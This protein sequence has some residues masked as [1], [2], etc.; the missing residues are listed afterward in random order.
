M[1]FRSPGAGLLKGDLAHARACLVDELQ[2]TGCMCHAPKLARTADESSAEPR[3]K[4][5]SFPCPISPAAANIGRVNEHTDSQL[6]RCYAQDRSEAAFAELVH[7]H[8]NFVYS[9]A[10]RMVCDPHHAE[11]VT[12]GVFVALAKSAGPLAERPVLA[13]WLHLTAQ[14]SEEHTSELQSH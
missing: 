2:E 6:L 7:R 1:L 9:A 13:G 4:H 5:L 10:H 12:Q 11:D 14:R 3:R 8:V